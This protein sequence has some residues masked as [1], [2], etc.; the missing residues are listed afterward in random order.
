M[1]SS[2]IKDVAARYVL[3]EVLQDAN[4]A[5]G[6]GAGAVGA[7]V[8]EVELALQVY[9]AHEVAHHHDGAAQD[10]TSSV[11]RPCNPR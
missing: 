2:T 10:A 5:A 3:L 1:M 4:D 7:Y 8:H 9:V 11:S 6:G